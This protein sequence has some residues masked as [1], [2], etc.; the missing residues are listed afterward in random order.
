MSE[1]KQMCANPHCQSLIPVQ[2]GPGLCPKC[3]KKGIKVP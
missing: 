2:I 3:K 1:I